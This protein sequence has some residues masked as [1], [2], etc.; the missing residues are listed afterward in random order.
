M[1]E[2]KKKKNKT[3]NLWRDLRQ[4]LQEMKKRGKCMSEIV[5]RCLNT[6]VNLKKILE[7]EG[8]E[9]KLDILD[10]MKIMSASLPEKTFQKIG[11]I[12]KII[13][14][15]SHS[16]VA[17]LCLIFPS[18]TVDFILQN[19]KGMKIGGQEKYEGEVSTGNPGDTIPEHILE[20]IRENRKNNLN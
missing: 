13:P 17:N 20:H 12:K 4:K 6:R 14:C 18:L 5:D 10:G 9:I 7:Q 1:L 2:K 15:F 11:E 16:V 19:I 8:V 3:I